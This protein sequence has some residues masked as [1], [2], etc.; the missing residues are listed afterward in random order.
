MNVFLRFRIKSY[1]LETIDMI[2]IIKQLNSSMHIN[3]AW[4]INHHVINVF[5]ILKLHKTH[6]TAILPI[7]IYLY[8]ETHHQNT[9]M[10]TLNLQKLLALL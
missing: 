4:N 10:R 7:S 9:C 5:D 3:M 6:D 8:S 1:Q 2:S